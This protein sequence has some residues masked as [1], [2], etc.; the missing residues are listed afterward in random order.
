[1]T[2]E[3]IKKQLRTQPKSGHLQRE[4]MVDDKSIDKEKCYAEFSVSSE[5][6]VLRWFGYEILDHSDT[7]IRMGRL[8][9]GAA[10]RDGHYG[11]QIGVIEKAW[12]DP[13][14]RKLRVGVRFSQNTARAVEIFKD[15]YDG[16]RR[17][18]SIDY[19]INEIR[20]EKE[21]ND[22]S[23]YRVTDWEPI[24]TCSTP[25]GADQH[26]GVGRSKDIEADINGSDINI[27]INNNRGKNPMTEEEKKQAEEAV[28]A[29]QAEA[30]RSAAE[31][32]TLRIKGIRMMAHDLQRNIPGVKLEDEAEKFIQQDKTEIDFYNFC[33]EK[34]RDPEAVRT[35]ETH[36]D[37]SENDK[38][39]Y[40]LARAILAQSEG[41]A[42]T[43]GIEKE[44]SDTLKKTVNSSS[45]GLLIPTNLMTIGG[46]RNVRGK[47]AASFNYS[48]PAQ[49]GNAVNE[50]PIAQSFIEYL[51]NNLVALQA[52]VVFM[53]GMTGEVPFIR[54]L[55]QMIASW[56]AE[57]ATYSA[58]G[59]TY[60][61]VVSTPKHIAAKTSLSRQMLLQSP[62]VNEPYVNRKLFGAISR[63][64]DR[65]LFYGPG[66]TGRVAGVKNIS[67]V[68]GT[69]GAAFDRSRAIAMKSAI[70]ADNAEIGSVCFCA[71][72]VTAGVLQDKPIA[73]N[74]PAFLLND[75]NVMVGRP[76]CESNQIDEGDLF[77]G[78]WSALYLLEW[79][80]LDVSSNPY[81]SGWDAGD[82]E[83]RAL[84]AVDVFAEYPQA[85]NVAEG[86]N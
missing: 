62:Y 16:I 29:A 32:E 30:K 63:G 12:L 83:V 66:T 47:R 82:I 13:A 31:K 19:E 43:L 8:S 6:P 24:H 2:L 42:D 65:D 72:P 75:D 39:R 52:G 85:F 77:Y 4:M 41:K 10:H 40:N 25:D 80:Y 51:H 28:K 35:P 79:G 53:P 64:I 67:G 81:G 38:K 69:V 74:Y 36:I 78:V 34:M 76:L 46:A 3:E 84:H 73:D 86:V 11:D 61:R 37:L 50:E 33:R 26:V 45:R 22:I 55:D 15:V 48:T 1:M 18:V 49:G 5:T 58:T 68:H 17:N 70:L 23:Y 21:E 9:D 54:E 20:F 57:S 60:S 71:N 14:E 59:I 56:I 7:S 44:V 27:L